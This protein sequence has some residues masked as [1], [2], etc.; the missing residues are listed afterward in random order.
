V[1]EQFLTIVAEVTETRNKESTAVND[2][3]KQAI[4]DA[5]GTVRELS[6]DQRAAWVDAMKPVWAKFEGDVGAENIEAA[7]KINAM[8]N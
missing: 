2:A 1:R 7:Q 3:A 5:G 6:A 4:I 8:M